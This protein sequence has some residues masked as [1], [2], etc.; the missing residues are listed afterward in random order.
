MG[1]RDAEHVVKGIRSTLRKLKDAGLVEE[2]TLKPQVAVDDLQS[3]MLTVAERWYR[4]GARR[5]ALEV[6][7]AFLE[8]QFTVQYDASGRIEK[9]VANSQKPI[10]WSKWLNVTVGNQKLPVEKQEY[11]LTL[12]DL[13]FE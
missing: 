8:G 12:D 7:E 9:L 1:N 10:T 13:G 3:E 11:E 4:V 6:L 5:G 2:D